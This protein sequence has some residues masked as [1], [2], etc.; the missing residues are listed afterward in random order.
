MPPDGAVETAIDVALDE[1][2][3][4]LT[5]ESDRRGLAPYTLLQGLKVR[6]PGTWKVAVR[7]GGLDEVLRAQ[8]SASDH[9]LIES[10]GDPIDEPGS[11]MSDALRQEALEALRRDEAPT[12]AGILKALLKDDMDLQQERLR[13]ARLLGLPDTGAPG[14]S[15]EHL[16]FDRWVLKAAMR[17]Y[18]LQPRELA[19][20][21]MTVTVDEWR[22]FPT[23]RDR[24]PF[25]YALRWD[26][27]RPILLAKP[28]IPL[29]RTGEGSTFNGENLLIKGQ[30][31][32]DTALD[33]AIGGPLNRVVST[34]TELDRRIVRG[35]HMTGDGL[36]VRLDADPVSLADMH[37]P[38][39]GAPQR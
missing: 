16:S 34:R 36:S 30:T 35:W 18:G 10:L 2:S 20:T 7:A 31:A 19:E 33:A 32:P 39:A 25:A 8:G 17:E 9:D 24:V 3:R 26:G 38:S 21:I 1:V 13:A 6:R 4:L 15:F 14:A 12:A 37:P 5:A 11:E 28:R 22:S 27:D 23:D 29:G